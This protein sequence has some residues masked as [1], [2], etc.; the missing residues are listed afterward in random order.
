MPRKKRNSLHPRA[1]SKPFTATLAQAGPSRQ[2]GRCRKALHRSCK[3]AVW[4]SIL[5]AVVILY[6]HFIGIPTWAKDR[7]IR[8]QEDRHR[9]LEVGRITFNPFRGIIA[10]DFR[11]YES[12]RRI[13]PFLETKSVRLT[14]DA[15]QWLRLKSGWCGIQV[16]DGTVRMNP[17]G[18]LHEAD[19]SQIIRVRGLHATASWHEKMVQVRNL[20][21]RVLGV[22]I[23]SEGSINF[24]DRKEHSPST[25]WDPMFGLNALLRGDEGDLDWL[26]ELIAQLN[27]IRFAQTPVL[28]VKF[29]VHPGDWIKSDIKLTGQGEG[30]IVRGVEFERL[31]FQAR[32]RKGVLRVE[33]MSIRDHTHFMEAIAEGDFS[34]RKVHLRVESELAPSDWLSLIPISWRDRL[35][36]MGYFFKGPIRCNVEMGPAAMDQLWR[37][38]AGTLIIQEAEAQGVWLES[39]HLGFNCEDD[40]LILQDID[41]SLG[42]KG[43]HGVCGGEIKWHFPSGTYQGTFRSQLDF[44][45]LLPVLSDHHARLV[46]SFT[47]KEEPLLAD[48]TFHGV[49]GHKNAFSI[50]GTVNGTNLFYRGAFFN[51]GR[52][53]LTISNRVLT[54][55]PLYVSR[56]E[57]NVNGR[58]QIDFEDRRI[59]LDVAGTLNPKAAGRVAGEQVERILRYFDFNG[60]VQSHVRGTI[61]LNQQDKTFVQIQAEGEKIGLH[62]F[63]GDRVSMNL[64]W[65]NR[66]VLVRDIDA[67]MYGGKLTGTFATDWTL[68]GQPLNYELTLAATNV[69]FEDVVR[70]LFHREG[71]PYRGLITG[72]LKLKGQLGR[73][74]G[75]STRGQGRITIHDGRILSIRLF[76]GLSRGLSKI[77]PG[78]GFSKQTDFFSNFEIKDSVI[79]SKDIQLEGTMFSL[80]ADGTYGLKDKSIDYSVEFKLL[81][82]SGVGNVVRL[83]TL[84]ITKLLEFDLEGTL[85]NPKWRPKNLP[86]ELF[87]DFE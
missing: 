32:C 57:E 39:I 4:L 54:L 8:G 40:E 7:W 20:S 3:A 53:G 83:V 43:E 64:V 15:F 48:V 27:E 75:P 28:F 23:R 60:P 78:L 74:F 46:H 38:I 10:H 55:A 35:D 24:T 16:R 13:V 61:N 5:V 50:N 56:D 37:K 77:Y 85:D 18:M 82:E 36:N 42:T 81:R 52:T 30:M 51:H 17:T 14:T 41:A 79:Q 45:A 19:P 44:A 62:S 22:Q 73:D 25:T 34:T 33:E 86:K 26:P 87:S 9:Y 71:E 49:K 70:T 65:S 80:F 66:H 1:I 11:Y 6:L 67:D 29:S 69:N 84:P 63:I 68:P 72:D 59:D 47:I 12:K 31:T 58:I 76:G 2:K 21:A